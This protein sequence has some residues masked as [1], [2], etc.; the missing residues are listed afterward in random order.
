[1]SL[2]HTNNCFQGQ[3]LENKTK[4]RVMFRKST[5]FKGLKEIIEEKRE[6]YP[7]HIQK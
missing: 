7:K 1:M 4:Q 6:G 3:T 2:E 5:K